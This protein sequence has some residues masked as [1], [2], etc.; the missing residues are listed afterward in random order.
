MKI[1]RSARARGV[2]MV[3]FTA[4][5]A[6][7]G[8]VLEG[9]GSSGTVLNSSGRF[10]MNSQ[11]SCEPPGCTRTGEIDGLAGAGGV[12]IA[13]TKVCGDSPE[14]PVYPPQT[15][16]CYGYEIGESVRFGLGTAFQFGKGVDG[17]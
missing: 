1:L 3:V 4:F 13:T 16:S 17:G 12:V 6:C 5:L 14:L 11:V 8:E 10:L 7:S 15:A 9:S 2:S